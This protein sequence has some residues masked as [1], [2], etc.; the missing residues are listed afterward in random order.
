MLDRFR[1]SWR[2][3]IEAGELRALVGR[4]P[5]AFVHRLQECLRIH[6]I[7]T[8]RLECKGAGRHARL[9][10]SRD[11]PQTG[12]QAIRNAWTPPTRPGPTSGPRRSG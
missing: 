1:L 6:D 5:V 10:F 8:G 3:G 9:I 7:R 12:R 4:P 2:I 11:F